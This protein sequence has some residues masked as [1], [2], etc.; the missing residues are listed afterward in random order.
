MAERGG[1]RQTARPARRQPRAASRAAAALAAILRASSDDQIA[2]EAE[3]RGCAR[4]RRVFDRVVDRIPDSIAAQHLIDDDLD[5]NKCRQGVAADPDCGVGQLTKPGIGDHRGEQK[6]I[7]HAPRAQVD[8][9]APDQPQRHAAI[10]LGR[11]HRPT[12]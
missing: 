4:R 3:D 10:R 1:R 2:I 8:R 6:D 12:R 11:V 7:E 5:Y 9:G